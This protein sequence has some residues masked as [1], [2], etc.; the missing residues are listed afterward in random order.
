VPF[1]PTPSIA[2][3]D[4]QSSA[5]AAS[6]SGGSTGAG[7]T[8]DVRD[9]SGTAHS[10]G[11]SG[12]G[13]GSQDPGIPTW[14]AFAATLLLGATVLTAARVR[15]L[16]HRRRAAEED[17]EVAALTRALART[18][19]AVPPRT[20]LRQLEDRLERTAGPPAARYAQMLRER[21]FGARGGRAPDGAARRDLRRALSRGRG[22]RIRLAAL[23]ALP[24]VSFRRD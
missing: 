11:G 2:P 3:A 9:Q 12:A 7:E 17:P 21:R 10:S 19:E 24:P 1:D 5:D 16:L 6:A 20:T 23:T 22:P 18:G 8:Q 14:V 4:S 15:T 13:G